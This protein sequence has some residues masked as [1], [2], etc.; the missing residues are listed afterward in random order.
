MLNIVFRLQ[1]SRAALEYGRS[2]RQLET[3]RLSLEVLHNEYM[4]LGIPLPNLHALTILAQNLM[5]EHIK[6]LKESLK[7]ALEIESQPLTAIKTLTT[8][9][10][11]FLESLNPE[12]DVISI[13]ENDKTAFKPIAT[14]VPKS[15]PIDPC[16]SLFG[17]SLEK[18][19]SRTKCRILPLLAKEQ[20]IYMTSSGMINQTNRLTWMSGFHN[21]I[22]YL[23]SIH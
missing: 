14:Y 16:L 10:S 7:S 21:Q 18:L 4:H 13:S 6:T 5:T 15:F 1:A 23:L 17:V 2:A 11:I 22:I 8:R 19:E 9:L 3:L 12:K 20:N